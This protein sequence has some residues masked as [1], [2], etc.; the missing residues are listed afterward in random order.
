M[1]MVLVSV[2]AFIFA[3]GILVAVHEWGHYIVA[4]ML[5]VKVLR[6]SVGFGRPIWMRRGGPDQTEYCISSLPLGGY[7]KLLDEREG[8]VA[9]HDRG[10]S[11]NS[12]PIAGR[13]AIL[14]AGPLMNFFFAVVAFWVMFQV[15]VP[16]LAPV[17]GKVAPDSAA[18]VAGLVE[19]DRI[20]AINGYEVAT[21]EGTL[22]G[23]LDAVLEDSSI[24]IQV[25]GDLNG[26]G[27]R[28]L[29]L[30]AGDRIAELTEPGALLPGLGLQ[31]WSPVLEPVL[32]EV[33]SGGSAAAAGMMA[34]DRVLAADGEVMPDWE[35]WVNFVRARPGQQVE[36]SLLRDGVSLDMLL[37]VGSV[38]EDDGGTVGRIGARVEVPD[39]LY[40][41]FR[42][43]QR[44]TGLMG[45]EKAVERTWSMSALTVRMRDILHRS[46]WRHF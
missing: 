32:S 24:R 25:S 38:E 8:P 37:L 30:D 26:K 16:G 14:L 46:G 43:A 12:Q 6:F 18:A 39:D 41:G 42:A 15:G 27:E 33:E 29:R 1:N 9:E 40:E 5:G 35:S 28:D 34:G 44:Y 21:W 4:R 2:L 7:V 3:I 10:R 22:L 20:V 11:F 31:I 13:I 23:L 17:V 36:V 45:L 19:N